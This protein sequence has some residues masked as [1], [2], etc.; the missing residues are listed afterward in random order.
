VFVGATV[1]AALT[2]AVC[3]EAAVAVPA[4]LLAA[5]WTRMVVPTSALVSG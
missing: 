3:A 5:T 1:A 4:L 2:S